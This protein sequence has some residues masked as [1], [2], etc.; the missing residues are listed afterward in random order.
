MDFLTDI[1]F[2]VPAHRIGVFILKALTG[3]A[4]R[5]KAVLLGAGP[6]R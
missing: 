6:W 2:T 4:S 5:A 1:L 3:A